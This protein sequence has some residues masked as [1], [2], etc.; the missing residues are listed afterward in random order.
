MF[1]QNEVGDEEHN[2]MSCS[3][4]MFVILHEN[5]LNSLYK[6][7]QSFEEFDMQSLFQYILRMKD[8]NIWPEFLINFR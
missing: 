5:F 2:I 4:T 3:N 6:I 7:N 8:E 1:Y